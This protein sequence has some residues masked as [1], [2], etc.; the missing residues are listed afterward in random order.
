MHRVSCFGEKSDVRAT[1]ELKEGSVVVNEEGDVRRTAC[2][3]RLGVVEA[4][5]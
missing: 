2:R 5:D 3:R 1:E 4:F